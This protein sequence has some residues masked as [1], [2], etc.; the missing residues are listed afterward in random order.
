MNFYKI[1][2]S[3][4]GSDFYGWQIQPHKPTITQTL[5]NTFYKIFKKKITLLGASRTDSGVHALGQV[6]R[7]KADIAI[8]DEDLLAIWNRQLPKSIVIRS[9]TKVSPKFHPFVNVQQKIYYYTIFLKRPLPFIA[10][11]GWYYSFIDRVDFDIFFKGLNLYKGTHN[12]GSFCKHEEK[13][14]LIRTIDSISVKQLNHWNAL[15][16][17]IKGKSFLRFQIRRMIGYALDVARRDNLG[18]DYIQYMLDNPNPEQNLVKA[19]S[20]GLCLRKVIYH[21]PNE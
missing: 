18:V 10:R 5:Q 15:L 9:I 14:S 12:F 13:K 8:A 21:E 17:T 19:A 3:Y 20:S 2:I 16:I 4:D 1:I 11:Y 7:F 6:A